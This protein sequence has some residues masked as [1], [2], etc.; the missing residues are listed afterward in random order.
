MWGHP[1]QGSEKTSYWSPIEPV[2]SFNK[3]TSLK[4]KKGEKGND[5]SSGG[6]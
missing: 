4:Q 3:E 1:V 6:K 5:Q 2:K